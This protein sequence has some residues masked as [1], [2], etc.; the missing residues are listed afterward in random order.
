MCVIRQLTSR[1]NFASA[2]LMLAATI[3]L[4]FSAA[5]VWAVESLAYSFES[6][7]DD[8]PDQFAPNGG[9]ITVAADL[10]TGVT[11]G[12]Y[13]MKT[14]VEA[15]ATFVGALTTS[16]NPTPTGGSTIIGDPPGID[17][18]LFDMTI[19]PGDEFPTATGSF[20]VIG[21]TIF[22]A[23]QPDRPGG[24]LFG[25]QAQF[26]HEVHIDGLA[27]G[28]YRDVRIDL[29]D[30]HSHPLT[31][32]ANQSFNE[33]FGEEGSGANDIIP[34]AFQLFFNKSANLPLTVYLD[35]VRVGTNPPG[36]P[37]DYN[38][39]GTVNAADYALWRDGG[40]LLNEVADPGTISAADYTE[41]RTRF[42]NASGGGSSS[43]VPEP[44]S[45]LLA[46]AAG[47][48]WLASRWRRFAR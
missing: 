5:E 40:A 36:V 27:A 45:V 10:T 17:Y 15:G 37:G 44:G 42:G 14:S 34:S 39:D 47:G 26:K 11:D 41:W 16:V 24:Q 21:V 1:G 13:S 38:G 22:G 19:A 32:V 25:L 43:A 29:A 23:S 31:F 28:T 46:F 8:N 30:A 7:T 48:C 18:V 6:G 33:I 35:N 2:A 4:L 12:I 9:G 20:A 3:G